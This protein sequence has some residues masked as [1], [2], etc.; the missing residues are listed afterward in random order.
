MYIRIRLPGGHGLQ[1]WR[2]EMSTDIDLGELHTVGWARG[3]HAL[4]R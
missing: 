4:Q 3:P 1:L 2:M